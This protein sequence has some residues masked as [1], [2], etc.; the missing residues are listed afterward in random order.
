[1]YRLK[2]V[3]LSTLALFSAVTYAANQQ[4]V[5]KILDL[6]S[7]PAGVAFEI[8]EGSQD[9]LAPLLKEVELYNQQLKEK[10]PEIKTAVLT[11]GSEQFALLKEQPNQQAVEQSLSLTNNDIEVHVCGTHASWYGKTEDD[12][13][14]HVNVAKSAVEQVAEFKALG[15]EVI[16]LRYNY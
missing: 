3:I 14:G 6:N 16:R 7:A 10:F 8:M 15:Y 13:L 2:Q 12:F 1:M 4:Q 9:T 11:H 5:D